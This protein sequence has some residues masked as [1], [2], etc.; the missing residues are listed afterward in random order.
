MDV[1]YVFIKLL[2][3][4]L[5]IAIYMRTAKFI[6]YYYFLNKC[7]YKYYLKD[8]YMNTFFPIKD[9]YKRDVL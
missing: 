7:N 5:Y 8:F 1:V 9:I 6:Y 2:K 4:H 3:L